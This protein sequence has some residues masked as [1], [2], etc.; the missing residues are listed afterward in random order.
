[1]K[2]CLSFME[3]SYISMWIEYRIMFLNTLFLGDSAFLLISQKFLISSLRKKQSSLDQDTTQRSSRTRIRT[4]SRSSI[5]GAFFQENDY[6][7]LS[8]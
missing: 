7:L 8:R 2:L 3:D 5:E 6:G 4:T 1:M